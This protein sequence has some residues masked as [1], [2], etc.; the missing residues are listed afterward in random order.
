MDKI[1]TLTDIRQTQHLNTLKKTTLRY[2][3]C[4]NGPMGSK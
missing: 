4:R 1:S 2:Q 3:L